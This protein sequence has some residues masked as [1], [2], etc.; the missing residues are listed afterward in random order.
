MK[1]KIIIFIIGLLSGAI[2][3][4]GSIFIYTLATNV[5]N[6]NNNSS[7]MQAP[8]GTPPDMSNG[9]NSNTPPDMSNEQNDST[10]TPP[11]MPNG[12]QGTNTPPEKPNDNQGQQS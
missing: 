9:Q 2:I 5:N 10:N 3:S 12:T 6:N 1:D 4:T 7:S 11:E 8:T